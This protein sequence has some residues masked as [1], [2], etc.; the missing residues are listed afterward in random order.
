MLCVNLNSYVGKIL[1]FK[2]SIS[3][4]DIDSLSYAKQHYSDCYL[5]SSLEALSHT[6]NGRNILK[7]QIEYDDT[8]S[9]NINCY[10][11]N[12]TGEKEKFS[13]PTSVAL[14]GYEDVYDNQANPIVRSMDISVAE[15]EKRHKSK[16]WYCKL[17]D[18]FNSYEFEKNSPSHFMKI[19]TG[20][21]PISIAEKDVNIDLTNYKD[22]VMP[23][24]ERM[25]KEK[26][27]SFVIGTGMKMLDGRT[28]HVYV[29]E[30][31][32]ME[33]G[34]ITVKEKRA[35]SP[36]VLKIDTAL[37]TFKYITG[38]FNSDLG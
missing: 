36:Q 33:K 1:S 11:Y 18:T 30:D 29:I 15:Y 23:L 17:A 4:K 28:W 37:N 5:M 21:D 32:D 14:K 35:N 13:V 19:L 6:K 16:P 34:T 31:V 24:L 38:Y 22:K 27:Y 20:K 25:S 7:K 10:L 26:D 12:K 2:S 9:N 8:N 3:D